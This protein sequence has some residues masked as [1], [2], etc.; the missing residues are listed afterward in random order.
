MMARSTSVN[1][2]S[3]TVGTTD[4]DL[5]LELVFSGFLDIRCV[6]PSIDV[7]VVDEEPR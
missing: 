6:S 3:E 2:R 4:A 7:V 1:T 5:G